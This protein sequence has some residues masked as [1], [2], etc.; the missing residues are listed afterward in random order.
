MAYRK[1]VELN[2]ENV[3]QCNLTELNASSAE[4]KGY[5]TH[6]DWLAH[7]DRYGYVWKNMTSRL[8]GAK[9]VLDVGCGNLQLPHFLWRNRCKMT[10]GFHY[11]GLELRATERWV[12]NADEHWQVPITL[13]KTDFMLDD[14]TA[15]EGWPG[16]FD[17]VVSFEVMEHLPREM[18][19][20]YLKKLFQWTAPGGSCFFST[21]NAGV[22]DSTAE[23]HIGPDGVSRE[24]SYD[25]KMA[26]V[27]EIG[28]HVVDTFG[29]FCGTTHLP[30]DV[31]ER[32]KSDPFLAKIK[33][34]HTH[35]R[36][37]TFMAVNYP[38]HSNNALMHLER[39]L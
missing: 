10:E 6:N 26:L 8:K 31:Q 30:E 5:H 24:W 7:N 35:S 4:E 29:T 36:F 13:V 39:P 33:K 1:F 34:Y 22:S 2:D 23:N 17:V 11:W 37:T 28:F 15:V 38:E 20:E 18:G 3:N 19:R 27:N 25:D 12:P 14:L 16:Q 21:P 32:I 9:S